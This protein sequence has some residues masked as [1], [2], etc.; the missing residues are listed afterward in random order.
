[1]DKETE[2]KELDKLISQ[3]YRCFENAFVLL[4]S[5]TYK[6]GNKRGMKFKLT[7]YKNGVP[8]INAINEYMLELREYA[9]NKIKENYD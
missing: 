9:Q 5:Y 1:M 4:N 6:G 3:A 8:V 7:D 2:L